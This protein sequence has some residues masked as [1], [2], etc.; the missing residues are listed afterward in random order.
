LPHLCHLVVIEEA[1]R[2]LTNV[3]GRG[4]EEEAN[5]RGKAV[6]AFANLLS[7]IRAYGQGVIVADQ[8]PVKLA[9]DV[10][11]NTN[12]KIVHRTVAADDRTV[13]AGAMLMTEQ[14]S[15]S[16]ATLNPG[17]A[18]V[19]AEG[20]DAPLLVKVPKEDRGEW[21]DNEIVRKRIG[22]SKQLSSY[23]KSLDSVVGLEKE[24]RASNSAVFDAVQSVTED[25]RFRR[26]FA[27]FVLTL[28]ETE[29]PEDALERLWPALLEYVQAVRQRD[30]MEEKIIQGIL[31][32]A[33]EWFA[34]RRGSQSGWTYA[35]T[36]ELAEKLTALIQACQ[37][38][39]GW[40]NPLAAFR[41]CLYQL[42][43]R[44]FLPYRDCDRICTQDT[45]LCLYRRAAQDLTPA[46]DLRER[47]NVAD[48]ED[49]KNNE[50][51]GET[52]KV[53]EDAAQILIDWHPST[54]SAIRRIGLC[55]G[56][57]MLASQPGLLPEIRRG[58]MDDLIQQAARLESGS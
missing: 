1:H 33:S 39:S 7:E 13:L 10:V 21:P 58:I 25:P 8:V 45:P 37:R 20:E 11:K 5:P 4:R 54:R 46:V 30:V 44:V 14:Q 19:F 18:V 12:L 48:E 55:Y 53:C 35:E 32:T 9:P 56:Q 41:D 15:R 22:S 24:S 49:R 38:G 51:R 2:L 17:Y 26:D 31:V 6:E 57:L 43:A 3:E 29:M 50:G 40:A 27:R 52:W 47:W 16:V 34:E 28:S 42:N 23:R 36:G